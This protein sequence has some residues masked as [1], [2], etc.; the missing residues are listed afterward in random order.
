MRFRYTATPEVLTEG[1]IPEYLPLD[2]MGRLMGVGGGDVISVTPT[3]DTAIYAAD[4]LL[5]NPATITG[6]ALV[7]GGTVRL[8]SIILLDEDD[9]GVAMDLLFLDA[10][11]SLGTFNTAF[12]AS[13][14]LMRGV[15]GRVNIATG[16]YV[17]FGGSRVALKNGAGVEQLLKCGAA[18]KDLY[19]AAVTRGG[20]PTYTATGLKFKFGIERL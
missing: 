10:S 2:I 20:T 7:V 17:D 8:K 16:D 12:A 11:T 9:Q 6:A 1:Q 13:D 4:E 5:F 19:V 15:V 3:P 18:S 14:T